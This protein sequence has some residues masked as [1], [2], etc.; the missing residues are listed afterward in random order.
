MC[1]CVFAC[2][3]LCVPVFNH[4]VENNPERIHIHLTVRACVRVFASVCVDVC[5]CVRVSV[6]CL[7]CVYG[8]LFGVVLVP[9]RV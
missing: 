4:L 3:C 6:M 5:A 8:H 2:V 9:M 1:L 7:G